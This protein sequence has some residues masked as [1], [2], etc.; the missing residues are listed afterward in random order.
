MV[1][2]ACT[3]ASSASAETWV[4]LTEGATGFV[5]YYDQDSIVR[6]GN[7]AKIWILSD[8]SNDPSVPYARAKRMYSVKCD[9]NVAALAAYLSYRKDRTVLENETIPE[10]ELDF[11]NV[12]PGS[13]GGKIL[14]AACSGAAT[15]RSVANLS[16][17]QVGGQTQTPTATLNVQRGIFL[18]KNFRVGMSADEAVTAL[19]S[20]GATSKVQIDKK[21]WHSCC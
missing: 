13:V 15:G 19:A 6:V 4:K 2:I 16:P 1:V 17:Y 3:V 12:S 9:Q 11:Q 20:E 5:D 7:N 14:A 21:N 8:H 18:W 10:R